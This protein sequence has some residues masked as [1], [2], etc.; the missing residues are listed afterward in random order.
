VGGPLRGGDP[1]LRLIEA[2]A[3][4]PTYFEAATPPFETAEWEWL[5]VP[6]YHIFGSEE[7]SVLT[8][9]VAERAPAPYLGLNPR[10]ARRLDLSDGQ[11]V[12]L[13]LHGSPVRLRVSL[14][15]SLPA[16]VAA[17]PAG[18][19]GMP[20]LPRPERRNLKEA[21]RGVQ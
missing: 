2:S 5:V 21:L 1:G 10:D 16:G 4:R 15:P 3:V 18:I 9:G 14:L 11:A 13:S 8:P 19:P 6:L 20:C 17:L 7:T 12:E